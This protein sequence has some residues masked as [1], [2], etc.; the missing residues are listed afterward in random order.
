MAE[1]YKGAGTKI[2]KLPG[3]QPVLQSAAEEI[4][5][6]A[7]AL[8]AGHTDTGAYVSSLKVKTVPGRSGVRDRLVIADD[9]ASTPIEFGHLTRSGRWVEGQYIL[10]RAL[11]GG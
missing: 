4:R 6:K 9:P 7:V 5:G 11:Y 1:V 8:A 3:L 2:A 10:T